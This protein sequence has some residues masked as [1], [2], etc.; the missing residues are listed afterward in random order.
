MP[1]RGGSG[2]TRGGDQT[3][4]TFCLIIKIFT[5][6]KGGGKCLP[7]KVISLKKFRLKWSTNCNETF[8]G[9]FYGLVFYGIL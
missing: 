5:L 3:L 9:Y 6:W 1:T 4:E 7:E 8:T 2:A